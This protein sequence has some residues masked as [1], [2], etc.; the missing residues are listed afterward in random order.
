MAASVAKP[1]K[2]TRTRNKRNKRGART[3]QAACAAAAPGAVERALLRLRGAIE[4][5]QERGGPEVA[6]PPT[7]AVR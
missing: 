1:N 7:A 6:S 3:I 5:T 4:A 2:T